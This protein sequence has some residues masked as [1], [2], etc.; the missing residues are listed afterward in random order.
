MREQSP[1]GGRIIDNGSISA[2]V[3]RPRSIAYTATKHAITGH[4]TRAA[5]LDG[6]SFD[7][8]VG[9]MTSAMRV[10]K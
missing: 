5:A 7:I 10:L 2:N 3:P 8:A 1:R 6:K 4:L 9:Q